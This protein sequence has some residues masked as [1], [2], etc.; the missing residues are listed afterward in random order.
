MNENEKQKVF[1]ELLKTEIEMLQNIDRQKLVTSKLNK[2]ERTENFLNELAQSKKWINSYNRY[3]L[4]T[5]PE[6]QRAAEL[7]ELFKALQQYE[8]SVVSSQGGKTR[9]PDANQNHSE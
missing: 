4:V 9:S 3:N 7:L 8:S 6:S 5:T 2:K 1:T